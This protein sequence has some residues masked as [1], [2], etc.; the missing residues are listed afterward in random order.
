MQPEAVAK[1]ERYSDDIRHA[2]I[3]ANREAVRHLHPRIHT[4]HVLIALAKERTGL[5]GTLLR[6][7]GL[8]ARRVRRAVRRSL[9][10]AWS[11]NFLAK[12]P[13]SDHLERIVSGAVEHAIFEKHDSVGT[14]GVLLAMVR[15]DA[16][17]VEILR[18]L[19]I[20]VD[21]LERDLAKYL[22]RFMVE[23]PGQVLQLDA[24][25]DAMG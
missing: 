13:L 3:I 24:A 22:H 10:R 16:D 18:S 14:G 12:L 8:T 2:M 15:H 11:L 23:A 21:S 17:T 20:N 4:L 1:F 19:E 6:Q 5:A 7:R 9:A 25:S